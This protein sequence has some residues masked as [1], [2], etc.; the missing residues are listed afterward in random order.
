[1]ARRHRQ[2]GRDGRPPYIDPRNLFL[3]A[4]RHRP[5]QER[6]VRRVTDVLDACERV[7]RKKRFE[8]LTMEDIARA[9]KIQTGSLYHFFSDKNAVVVSLLERVLAQE[10]AAFALR[11]TD[12]RLSLKGYLENLERRMMQ[13]WRQHALLDLCFAFQRHPVVW[14]F[15]LKQRRLTAIQIGQKLRQLDSTLTHAHAMRKGAMISATMATLID[16][17][18]YLPQADARTFREETLGMLAAYVTGTKTT[19]PK[20]SPR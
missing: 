10:G 20:R 13:V 14:K 17:L 2:I 16:N 3:P 12:M 4:L 6:G 15:I 18:M 1:M 8:D 11:A 19:Q 7:L 9:A 5:I